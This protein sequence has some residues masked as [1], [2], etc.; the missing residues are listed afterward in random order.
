VEDLLKAGKRVG[1]DRSDLQPDR[2]SRDRWKADL[3]IVLM[4]IPCA[5]F[6]VGIMLILALAKSFG[7]ETGFAIGMIRPAFIFYPMLAFGDATYQGPP[8]A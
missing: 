2:S 4:L 5:N 6:V 1:R 3:V 7:K 8:A